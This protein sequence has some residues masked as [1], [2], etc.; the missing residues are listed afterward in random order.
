MATAT[1]KAPAKRKR[2]AAPKK[3]AAKKSPAKKKAA[4]KKKPVKINVFRDAFNE[5]WDQVEEWV[6][7]AKL[8]A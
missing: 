3:A 2:T 6:D 7:T 8:K 4:A 5:A 1:K